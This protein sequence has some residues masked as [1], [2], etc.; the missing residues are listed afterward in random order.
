MEA[1]TSNFFLQTHGFFTI[2]SHS[3]IF[4]DFTSEPPEHWKN[5]SQV[6]YLLWVLDETRGTSVARSAI[7]HGTIGHRAIV[8]QA[9]AHIDLG[10]SWEMVNH[11]FKHQLR[12]VVYPIIYRVF[13]HPRWY[14]I[15]SINSM[16]PYEVTN[17]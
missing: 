8:H 12:L 17:V 11:K 10:A 2:R 1:M 4:H 16:S 14:R 15:S 7:G 9:I 6:S 5:T 3:F 13:L